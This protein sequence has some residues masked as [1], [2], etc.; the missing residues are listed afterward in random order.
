MD[1]FSGKFFFE[2]EKKNRLFFAKDYGVF[3]FYDYIGSDKSYLKKFFMAVP[4]V[5]LIDNK[6]VN[7]KD[8]LT[9]RVVFG[10]FKKEL[11]MFLSS[12]C[13]KPFLYIGIWE[14]EGDIISGKINL[15]GKNILCF[16]K[17][18]EVQGL[19][20][21]KVENITIRRIK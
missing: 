14:K 4:K 20:W 3:Y 21:I 15:N 9:P 1:R 13:Y 12:F 18:D 8:T 6:K 17:I 5:P 19:S 2:D 7:W 16:G 11:L 10:G